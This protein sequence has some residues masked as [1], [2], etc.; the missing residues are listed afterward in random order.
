MR[1]VLTFG[2]IIIGVLS[3]VLHAQE[4]DVSLETESY[5]LI[6]EEALDQ[7]EQNM[8]PADAGEK[9]SVE[10]R[11]SESLSVEIGSGSAAGTQE[12][13]DRQEA[14]FDVRVTVEA[15][16]EETVVESQAPPI[17]DI[18]ESIIVQDEVPEEEIETK[19]IP[20]LH[21]EASSLVD[22]LE[23]MKSPEGEVRFN[24]EDRTL[25]LKDKPKP[26][27]EMSSYVKEIDVLFETEI[28][29]LEYVRAQDIIERVEGAL[30]ENI[31]QVQSDDETNSLIVTDTPGKIVEI[32]QFI[33][34]LDHFHVEVSISGKIL[35]IILNDEHLDG[36]DW[37]AI[38]S[39]YQKLDLPGENGK[40]ERQLSIGS[41]TREDYE[42]L[43]EA[44]D[45]VGVVRTVLEKEI[46]AENETEQV[47]EAPASLSRGKEI[48]FRLEPAARKDK[49]LD[50][51]VRMQE[52]DQQGVTVQ[53]ESGD[54]I[55]I[56]GLFDDIMVASTWK[57]PLLGD[58][59]LLGFV[60]RNEEQEARRTEII[61]FF[62]VETVEKSEMLEDQ[63]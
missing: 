43:L 20:L 3:T 46:K 50:V 6:I 13:E 49:P 51:I 14:E 52:A 16:E 9:L 19:I 40:D 26:L 27:E 23:R 22:A 35:E 32:K 59:P 53:M 28:F 17:E 30:T 4:R 56:G 47:I 54:T 57:I 2:M 15:D 11:I 10:P 41:I 58:L 61:T 12:V 39:G 31:G 48:H 55:V 8:D 42:I 62:T 34:E 25:I 7:V 18:D 37:E 63:N 38:V 44:L 29:A 21:A 36:V 60:F 5:D 24:E 45:T 33:R 1:K